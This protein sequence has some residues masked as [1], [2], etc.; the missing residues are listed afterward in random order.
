MLHVNQ[1]NARQIPSPVHEKKKGAANAPTWTAATN[2]VTTQSILSKRKRSWENAAR[3]VSVSTAARDPVVTDLVLDV[4]GSA[5]IVANSLIFEHL[6][7]RN[8]LSGRLTV[9]YLPTATAPVIQSMAENGTPVI[10]MLQAD[11]VLSRSHDCQNTVNSL[12]H[13]HNTTYNTNV[14]R[15]SSPPWTSW[16]RHPSTLSPGSRQVKQTRRSDCGSCC[17]ARLSQTGD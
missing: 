2:M 4:E 15:K 17:L 5:V 3:S 13:I 8:P 11:S 12:T 16:P 10:G 7:G 14:P 1:C 6:P 9:Q